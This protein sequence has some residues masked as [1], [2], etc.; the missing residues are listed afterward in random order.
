MARTTCWSAI[1]TKRSSNTKRSRNS[2]RLI[3][4]AS[5]TVALADFYA[6]NMAGAVEEGRRVLAIY[7]NNVLY[8]N[9]VGLFAMYAGDF[10]RAIR[11]WI[12]C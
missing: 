1:T 6:R 2:F 11:E 10:D 7:P 9:N 8:L 5:A 3:P 4:P 12:A